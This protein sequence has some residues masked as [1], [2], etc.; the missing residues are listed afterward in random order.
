MKVVVFILT[1][2]LYSCAG[3]V[4]EPTPFE[5]SDKKV[6]VEGCEALK[7]EVEEHNKK[8]KEKRIADC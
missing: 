8:H 6:I 5:V 2:F 1:I 3:S 7:K 4:K